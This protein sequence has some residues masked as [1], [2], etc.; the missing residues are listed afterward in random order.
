MYED[1]H[2]RTNTIKIITGEMK[3]SL[4]YQHKKNKF[5]YS[6]YT[7][8]SCSFFTSAVITGVKPGEMSNSYGMLLKNSSFCTTLKSPVTI[9]LAEQIMPILH[10]LC[11]NGSQVT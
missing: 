11:Y 8:R 5:S 6:I 2:Q 1:L 3:Y 10:I 7:G 4:W 9:G